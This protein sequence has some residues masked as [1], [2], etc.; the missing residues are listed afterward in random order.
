MRTLSL[1]ICL[2]VGGFIVAGC[3]GKSPTAFC[4]TYEEQVCARAYEC[5]DV[6]TKGTAAFIAEF[7]ASQSECNSKLKSNN[8]A[9]VTDNKPC[10]NVAATY[11]SDKADACLNDLKA[12]SCATF[13]GGTFSSGNCDN[14]C[15]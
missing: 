9:T 13:T 10:A 12:A 14:I 15:S 4:A 2:V 8:C 11:H 3:G 6:N 7:G 1:V 5:Y